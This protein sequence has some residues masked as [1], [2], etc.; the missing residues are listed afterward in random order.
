MRSRTLSVREKDMFACVH[1]LMFS[2]IR[3]LKKGQTCLREE[4]VVHHHLFVCIY[5]SI[6]MFVFVL[7]SISTLLF[8]YIILRS[9]PVA[10][11]L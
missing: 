8:L 3:L 2:L 7:A 9:L 11:F 5:A 1:V 4:G 10:R 6:H